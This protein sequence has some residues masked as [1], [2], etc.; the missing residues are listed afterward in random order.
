M[1]ICT[2]RKWWHDLR[3]RKNTR[4]FLY[5]RIAPRHYPVDRAWW[6]PRLTRVGFQLDR[7][8]WST[9]LAPQDCK[10]VL[11][12]FRR[13]SS[14][15]ASL[16]RNRGRWPRYSTECRRSSSL[17]THAR[18][19]LIEPYT[20]TLLFFILPPTR[21]ILVF[22]GL[23]NEVHLAAVLDQIAKTVDWSTFHPLPVRLPDCHTDNNNWVH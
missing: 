15:R 18:L 23:P 21:N 16:W 8:H 6:H 22:Y 3:E 13:L 1:N 14:S 4:L 17:K 7:I 12:S 20:Y 2:R 10:K 9:P 11:C 19:L 5:Q